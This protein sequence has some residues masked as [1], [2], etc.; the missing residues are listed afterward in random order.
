MSEGRRPGGLTALAVFHF[1]F[2][3][4]GLLGALGSL[5][6][7][8]YV[9][10][11]AEEESGEEVP[12]EIQGMLDAIQEIGPGMWI[13]WLVMSLISSLLLLFSG[14]GLLKQKRFLGRVLSNAYVL[15][16]VVYTGLT[17]VSMPAELGGG[18]I[19][20]PTILGLLYPGITALLVNTTFK[21]DL[22]N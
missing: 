6:L 16:A 9:T 3:G 13:A 2:G 19:T 17:A 21:E 12:E 20:I 1:I 22:V 4:F 11:V 5:A 15:L 18:G 14:F 7:M 10:A 8:P